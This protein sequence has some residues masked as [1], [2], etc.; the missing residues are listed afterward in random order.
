MR[1]G[2][3]F[4]I[5]ARDRT[6][7]RTGVLTLAHGRVATPAFMPVGTYGTVKGL[8]PRQLS[9]AGVQMVLSNAYH[10]ALRPGVETIERLG[11]IHRFMGW[12]APVLTD[13]GGFQVF[14]LAA[15]VK[16]DEEG[17]VF[18]SH[19]DGSPVRMTPEGVVDLEYRLGVDIGMAFDVCVAKPGDRKAAAD[20]AARTLRWTRRTRQA[21]RE[22]A[23]TA[24]FAIQQGGLFEDLRREAA[25]ALIELDFP[26][27]AVGGLSVGEAREETMA[28]A[29]AS[30]AML[31]DDKPRYMMGMGTPL[32]LV[33]L[34]GQGYDLFDCVLPTRNARNGSLFTRSGPFSIRNACHASVDEPLE[35]GCDCEACN[36]FSRGYLHHLAKRGEMLG[37]ILCSLHNVRFYQRLM[38][39]I[40]AALAANAYDGFRT[41]FRA[42]YRGG[43]D[44]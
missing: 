8:T 7:G 1:H 39:D 35:E 6:G 33:E 3:R 26:G 17:A 4:E 10:L 13:S 20:G 37:A 32:D 25:E 14:S 28:T 40:R 29:A 9:E 15:S 24:I 23:S 22:D 38:A 21:L 5:T 43:T 18:R 44:A 36:G 16:V 2:L 30:V 19:L 27:Y 41:A 34:C 42:R 31:P 11:G 12:S